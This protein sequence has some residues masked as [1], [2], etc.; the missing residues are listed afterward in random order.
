MWGFDAA[1]SDDILLFFYQRLE[2]LD[3]PGKV[4][5]KNPEV[6]YA[7]LENYGE[8]QDVI[9]DEPHEVLFGTIVRS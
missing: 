1:T 5:L 6:T 9:P 2:A 4:D 3:F 7:V 8:N